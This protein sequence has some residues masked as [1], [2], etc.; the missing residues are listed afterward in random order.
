MVM[1]ASRQADQKERLQAARKSPSKPDVALVKDDV[2]AILGTT[3][4]MGF[5][6]RVGN[7]FVALSGSDINHAVE[8]GQSL[9][10]DQAVHIVH[11]R[12]LGR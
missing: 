1:Y 3:E 2:Y 8:V 10:W 11:Y 12:Y 6:E 9:S 7:V 5:V 4:T